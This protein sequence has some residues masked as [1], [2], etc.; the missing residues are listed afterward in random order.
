MYKYKIFDAHC[1]TLCMIA[2]NGGDIKI[3]KYNLDVSRMRRYAQYTQVFACFIAPEHRANAMARFKRL[4]DIYDSCDF[5]GIRPLLS[6]EGC[7]MI[8][9]IEDV[10]Y[11]KSRDV[12]C[13]ALTWNFANKIAGGSEDAEQGLTPFGRDVVR[14]MNELGIII[15]VSH[16]NDR[17]FYDIEKINMGTLIATHSNSRSVCAHPRN[18]TDDMFKIIRDTGGTVGINLYPPFVS[19]GGE[20]KTRDVLKHIEHFMSLDGENSIGIG[21]DFDGVENNLPV[22][23]KGCEDLYKLCDLL[24]DITADKITHEN[25]EHIFT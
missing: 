23:V 13:A 18:L 17:S 16:L 21:A 14:R 19:C 15:D 6:V 11:L 4:A 25:W 20:C 22:D 24:D 1:D 9:S 5:D 7:E 10:D 12:R 2:D 3:N 8:Q